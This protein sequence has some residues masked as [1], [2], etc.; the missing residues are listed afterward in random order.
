MS[1]FITQCPH[2]NTAFRTSISQLQSADGMV[3]C[4]ACLRVFAADDNLLPSVDLRT[5]E[6]PVQEDAIEDEDLDI[7]EEQLVIDDFETEISEIE[8]DD[9]VESIF[10]LD[11]ADSLPN[12]L[13]PK[14]STNEPFWQLIEEDQEPPLEEETPSTALSEPEVVEEREELVESYEPDSETFTVDEIADTT[15]PLCSTEAATAPQETP[16]QEET[17]VRSRISAMDFDDDILN[18]NSAHSA[19]T[20]FS[21]AEIEGIS[22]AEAPLELS[23]REEPGTS[24]KGL[25]LYSLGLLFVLALASQYLWF[26]KDTLSQNPRLRGG[27]ESACALLSCTLPPLVDLRAIHSDTLVVRSHGEIA[28]ALSV[29]FQFRNDAQFPQPFPGLS[30]RFTDADNQVVAERRFTPTEYLPDGV[31]DLGVMPPGSPVQVRLDILDPGIKAINYEIS[32][33]SNSAR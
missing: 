7:A 15:D 30:L 24:R 28:N 3:R 31:A 16:L 10:T 32:F 29:N 25:L 13:S 4:G 22:S 2:C 21:A 20:R 14:I 9:N 1:L 19:Y 6:A 11:M 12:R 26:N 8:Q 23:W 18:D 33:Y 17:D 5:I 27:L